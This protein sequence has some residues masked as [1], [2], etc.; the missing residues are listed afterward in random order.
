MRELVRAYRM[1]VQPAEQCRGKA[2]K[3]GLGDR[4]DQFPAQRPNDGRLSRSVGSEK[5]DVEAAVRPETAF[6]PAG[7]AAQP[8]PEDLQG[9]P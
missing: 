6:R 4:A 2:E 7:D 1:P 8:G 5:D 3:L 9:A